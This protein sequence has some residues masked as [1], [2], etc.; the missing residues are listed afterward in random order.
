MKLP[1]GSLAIDLDTRYR[2]I[3]DAVGEVLPL[4][5]FAGILYPY[6]TRGQEFTLCALPYIISGMKL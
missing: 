3:A 4:T 6:F 2:L 5:T 1:N